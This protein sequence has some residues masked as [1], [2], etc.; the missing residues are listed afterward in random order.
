MS[1]KVV[2]MLQNSRAFV[3]LNPRSCTIDQVRQHIGIRRDGHTVFTLCKPPRSHHFHNFFFFFWKNASSAEQSIERTV[4]LPLAAS[5]SFLS[6]MEYV[7]IMT[8]VH[9]HLNL[10]VEIDSHSPNVKT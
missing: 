6:K 10:C 2:K 5:F 7:A 8:N 4:L 3:D 9:K 1:F